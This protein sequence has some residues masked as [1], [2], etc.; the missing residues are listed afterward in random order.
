MNLKRWKYDYKL[1]GSG[2]SS[3]IVNTI[4]DNVNTAICTVYNT[5]KDKKLGKVSKHFLSF[6]KINTTFS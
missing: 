5:C 1:M 3:A 4:R 6:H 2:Y